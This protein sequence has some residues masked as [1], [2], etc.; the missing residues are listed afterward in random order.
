[1]EKKHDTIKTKYIIIAWASFSSFIFLLFLYFL[2]IAK[3]FLGFMPT[4]EE[5]ENPDRNLATEIYASDS[6]I[7][8]TYFKENRA[9]SDF[10]DLSPYL[11]DA[12]ISTED[13][14]FFKH[15]GIDMRGLARVAIKT[16]LGG[17]D[18]AG[19]GSTISQQLAKMLFPRE[20][21]DNPFSII[22]RK[23]REWVIAVK[24]EKSYTKEEIIA[25]YFNQFDFLNLAVGVK[26]AAKVYFNTTPREL[27]IEE[28]AMLVGMAKNPAL[29]NPIRRY[30][31]TMHRRNVVLNQMLRYN[32][33]TKAQF[34]SLKV[35]PIVL[36]YQKVDHKMGSAPYFREFLRM[37]L[38]AKKPIKQ[39]YRN[40]ESYKDDS[41][42]WAEDP[43]YGWCNKNLK[44]DSTTYDI[45]RDGLKIYTSVNSRM[46]TYAE[47][48]V[49]KHLSETLQPA[50]FSQQ[51]RRS[52]APYAD[53]LS[54]EQIQAILS[55][56]MRSSERY[57]AMKDDGISK[58]SIIKAFKTPITTQLFAYK[59]IFD[60]L[61]SPWDSIRYMKHF[62]HAGMLA[63]EPE[64]GYVKAFVG[65]IDYMFFQYDPVIL[66]R[67]QVGSTFKPFLYTLA[68]QEGLSPCHQVP[69]VPTTFY[70]AD[71]TWTPQNA[72]DNRLGEMVSL[73]WGLAQSNNNVS[74]K[75][76]QMFKPEPVVNVA[77]EM[78]IKS[79]IPAVPSIC[80]GVAELTLYEMVGA[81]GTFINKGV[82]TQ[83]IFISRI[84]DKFGNVVAT[85]VPRRNEAISEE[86]A[87][88]MV[89]LLE[90]VVN[91]GTSVRLRFT[92]GFDNQIAGKTGTTNDHSDGWFMGL[93]PELVT[94]VW[95]GGDERGIRFSSIRDGQGANA[96]LPIWAYFMKDVYKDSVALGY[97]KYAKFERPESV[98]FWKIDCREYET[99]H[100]ENLGKTND[101]MDKFFD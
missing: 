53:E 37:M 5:L 1:M 36:N 67:R 7:I 75:L 42:R 92:Y 97:H 82:Y 14:R 44:P 13:A 19:G 50:F 83:P 59:G 51:K 23:F 94:G 17:D 39:N 96:A 91:R 26:S 101:Q 41:T 65:G 69:N 76:M 88:L 81:Y 47:N 15:S 100:N 4:F 49:R 35:L 78:G 64:S 77:H 20:R 29:F 18:N 86:T 46:Q 85:F 33:I 98:P 74:A 95:V 99:R 30:D 24:I 56:A 60:T 71:T 34:D 48:A 8:G 21:F 11:V 40:M 62:L 2:L 58:D 10:S 93:T 70:L 61:I 90:N 87:Y 3:G 45:Y 38:T 28:A 55:Q 52:K 72:D 68:M 63:M 27:K 54:K 32:N 66:Q 31:T 6:V 84:E 16:V 22:N 80:L 12:L 89:N 57:K 9:K 43:W 73:E 79:Y 25:M